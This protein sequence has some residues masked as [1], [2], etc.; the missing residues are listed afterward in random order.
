MDHT[1]EVAGIRERQFPKGP[2]VPF[3]DEKAFKDYDESQHPRDDHGR[4]TDAGGDSGGSSDAGKLTGPVSSYNPDWSA[5]PSEQRKNTAAALKSWTT[6][7]HKRINQ[8]LRTGEGK[9]RWADR[10]KG[11]DQVFR[12]DGHVL[13][14]DIKLYRGSN[15]GDK[16]KVGQ[17]FIDKGFVSMTPARHVAEHFGDFVFEITVPKGVSFFHPATTGHDKFEDELLLDRN[18]RFRV[19]GIEPATHEITTIKVEVVPR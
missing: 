16:L 9:D 18:T 15:F 2:A 11:I 14:H 6:T 10:I 12:Y 19:V 5:I 13:P 7:A 4:W 8:S 17:T 3:D 1:L